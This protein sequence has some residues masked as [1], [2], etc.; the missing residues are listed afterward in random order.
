MKRY[1]YPP[2]PAFNRPYVLRVASLFYASYVEEQKD[3]GV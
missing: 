3:S 2:V 1:V